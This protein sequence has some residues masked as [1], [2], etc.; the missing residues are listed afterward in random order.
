VAALLFAAFVGCGGGGGSATTTSGPSSALAPIPT[1]SSSIVGGTRFTLASLAGRSLAWGGNTSG[2]LGEGSMTGHPTPVPVVGLSLPVVA[3]AAGANH[4]LAVT[5]DGALF[6]WGHN[7]SGQLGDGTKKDRSEPA[8]VSGLHDVRGVAAGDGFSMALQADGSVFAW[9]NNQSGQL[10]D[11]KAPEDHA[12]PEVVSGLGAGSGVVEISAGIGFA[13]VRKAD[14][15][16]WEWGNGTSGELGDGTNGKQS[17]PTQV[18][19]LGP[20]S[21]VIS[22]SG[23]GSHALALKADGGVL[24]WGN[25]KSGELG[26]GTSPTNHSAP[27][28]VS[29]LGPGS[30]VV[31]I[32]AGESF[33]L[34]A[35]GDGTVV[36]W[37]NNESGELGDGTAPQDKSTPVAV[38]PFGPHGRLRSLGAGGSHSLAVA[39]DGTVWSW[40]NN[41]TGQ[42]GDGTQPTDQHTP[43]KVPVS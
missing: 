15:S 5:S 27:V 11:G 1:N 33:S 39:A 31:A 12:T 7:A 8:L 38:Q 23:G 25:N 32:A 20:G 43:V 3:I 4:S 36:A 17:A 10:G 6:A 34:A 41:S 28:G 40:G 24:A 22:I 14:G 13:M 21:G 9:G 26:D 35:K 30:G 29:G 16:V 2:E 37:G 18:Q 19:G 42:L